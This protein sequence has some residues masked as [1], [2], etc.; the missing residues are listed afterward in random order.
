VRLPATAGRVVR[1]PQAARAPTVAPEEIR[2]HAALIEKRRTAAC[3][4]ATATRRL[5]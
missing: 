2:R 5:R 1:D 4:G 3:R